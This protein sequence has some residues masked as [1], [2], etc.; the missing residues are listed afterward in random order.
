MRNLL[1]T[2]LGIA[3]ITSFI[4]PVYALT[5]SPAKLEVTIDPG[6]IQVHE[7]E[8]FN[9]QEDAKALYS[10]VENF[11]AQGESGAPHFTGANGGLA[12]WITLTD[13]VIVGA[14]ERVTVPFTINVPSNAKPGGYFAAVF[15]GSVPPQGSG[16]GEVNIGS[17]IGVLILLRVSG[18][19][20][21]VAGLNEFS[22]KDGRKF[23][24]TLPIQFGYAFNN[25]GGDRVVPG[26]EVKIKNTF[27]LT[28]ATFF[29]N[30]RG[31]SVLPGSIRRLNVV[32]GD[33]SYLRDENKTGFFGTAWRQVKDFHLGWYTAQLNLSWG[34]TNIETAKAS[35]HFFIIPWQLLTILAFII[36]LFGFVG[37]WGLKKYNRFIVAQAMRQQ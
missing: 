14:G 4:S 25:Q 20:E 24:S 32:W 9:E 8:L 12:T 16:G 3:I 28:S 30:E 11:E 33:E 35:Y 13:S 27:R 22:A 15:F 36:F 19:V 31:G 34:E 5:I 21:E 23:F 17:K 29:A 26:G 10:S 37:R 1:Y 2:V 7:I 6:Q 18:D